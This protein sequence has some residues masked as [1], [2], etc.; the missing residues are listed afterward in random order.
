MLKRCAALA[1][2]VTAATAPAKADAV[3]DF[4]KGKNVTFVIGFGVGNGYDTYSRTVAR[5]I[6]KYLPGQANVI[7]QNMPGAGSLAATQYIYSRP[8]DGLFVGALHGAVINGQV[9]G[10]IQGM[11]ASNEA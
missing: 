1:L 4:Y 6:G 5:S 8:A 11:V 2:A 9:T 10:A 7:V 3:T